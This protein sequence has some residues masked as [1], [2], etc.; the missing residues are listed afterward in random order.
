M[1]QGAGK[2]G[3]RNP[4]LRMKSELKVPRMKIKMIGRSRESD[5]PIFFA[6]TVEDVRKRER[7]CCHDAH[8]CVHTNR[9]KRRVMGVREAFG[10]R[11]NRR[12]EVL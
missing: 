7:H 6:Q 3:R 4:A 10:E 9:E 12:K 1:E 11:K 2:I 8:V 5:S